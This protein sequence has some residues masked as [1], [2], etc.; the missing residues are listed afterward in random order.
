MLVEYRLSL[1]VVRVGLP[2][3]T[4][5]ATTTKSHRGLASTPTRTKEIVTARHLEITMRF[6]KRRCCAPQHCVL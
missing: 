4:A 3:A 5:T 1:L 2:S 6:P